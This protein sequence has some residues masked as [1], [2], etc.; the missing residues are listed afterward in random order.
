MKISSKQKIGKVVLFAALFLYTLKSIFVGADVDEAYGVTAGY[1][2]VQGDLLLKDL[3]E[4][5]QTSAIFTAFFIR[6]ALFLTGGSLNGLTILLRVFFFGVQIAMT[7]YLYKTFCDCLPWLTKEENG[8]LAIVYYLTTP[9]CIY[10]PEYSNL[11]MWF[12]T[13]MA[14]FLMQFFCE[15]SS[16]RN[17]DSR[18]ILA[19]VMLACDV[20][21]YPSMVLFYP[22]CLLYLICQSGAGDRLKRF[23][24][25]SLPCFAGALLLIGYLRSYMSF[26]EIAENIGFILADGS[27]QQSAAEKIRI[28]GEDLVH[29]FLMIAGCGIFAALVQ[30][31]LRKRNFA[32]KAE[33]QCTALLPGWIFLW[34]VMQTIFQVAVWFRSD[35]NSG[36]PQLTYI[37]LPCLGILCCCKSVCKSRTG[38][39]LVALGAVNYS[40]LNLFSNWKPGNL[41]VYLVTGLLGGLLCIREYFVECLQ[42]RGAV[43]WKTLC[44]LW[45][46]MEIFGRSLLIIGGDPGS[47]MIYQIRGI[48]RGAVQGG[49][50]NS[51]MN[52]YRYNQNLQDFPEIVAPGSNVFYV[53]P[54]Q[55]FYL[56]GDCRVT[57]PSTISTPEYDESLK[58]YFD[59]H[60]DRF[61]DVVVM[62]SC[63]GDVSFLSEND[64]IYT[65][66]REEFQPD[67]IEE[68]PYVRVYKK[69][70]NE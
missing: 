38:L 51:Y 19:G 21:A 36:Y 24:A 62:E 50:L 30:K 15:A 68:Y 53:G 13:G 35:Y 48:S 26:T 29:L 7:W 40:C 34:M 63:Y 3:W 69:G 27:H 31:I 2:L 56:L 17:H 11:H 67:T 39:Y 61:P 60:P 55:Y 43:W 66:I 12:S 4:P 49:T 47:K 33:G 45:I 44:I 6:C 54:S 14:L 23:L 64:Y 32:G 41:S 10:V 65:W 22:V 18:L 37:F 59:R 9:K 1:R 8:L 20:L 25:F 16:K 42:K 46:A 52:S 5:H 57:A 58:V 28:A 70:G